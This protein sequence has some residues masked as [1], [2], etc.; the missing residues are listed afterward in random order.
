MNVKFNLVS[1]FIRKVTLSPPCAFTPYLLFQWYLQ[2]NE[3]SLNLGMKCL[4]SAFNAQGSRQ[5]IVLQQV[6]VLKII[7]SSSGNFSLSPNLS[8]K[9][10]WVPVISL[11]KI[12]IPVRHLMPYYYCRNWSFL[13][14]DRTN[15]TDNSNILLLYTF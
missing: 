1:M 2:S 6:G 12:F 13:A 10:V 7:C 4:N 3:N 5:I 9:L 14:P 8:E 11:C 15:F